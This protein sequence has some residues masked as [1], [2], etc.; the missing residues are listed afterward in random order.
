MIHRILDTE[1]VNAMIP[2]V[3]GIAD[4]LERQYAKAAHVLRS[5]PLG[6]DEALGAA[7]SL[8]RVEKCVRE[9]ESLGGRVRSFEPVRVDFIADVDGEIGYICWESGDRTAT[10]F[11]P[12]MERCEGSVLSV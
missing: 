3:Q 2:L 5:A 11:H 10:H 4:D 9:V 1:T 8:A 6:P 7:G 12:A